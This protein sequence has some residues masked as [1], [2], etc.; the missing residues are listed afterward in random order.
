MAIGRD[1][2][3]EMIPESNWLLVPGLE[4]SDNRGMES[5]SSIISSGLLSKGQEMAPNREM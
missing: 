5:P 2:L 4:L 3:R 1:Q